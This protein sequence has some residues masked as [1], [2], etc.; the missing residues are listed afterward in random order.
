MNGSG[1]NGRDMYII[2]K[3][4]VYIVRYIVCVMYI[5]FDI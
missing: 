5:L 1:E 4:Y 3:R 2:G